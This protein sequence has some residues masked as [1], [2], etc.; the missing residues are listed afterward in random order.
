ML[1]SGQSVS[2]L[3][4]LFV[5]YLLWLVGVSNELDRRRGGPCCTRETIS[6]DGGRDPAQRE[7]AR[8]NV[9]GAEQKLLGVSKRGAILWGRFV[10]KGRHRDNPIAFHLL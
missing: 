4:V 10:G 1:E 5:C 6:G 2:D 9:T 3:L 7:C 8:R